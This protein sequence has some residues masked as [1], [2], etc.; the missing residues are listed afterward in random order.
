MGDRDVNAIVFLYLV[1]GEMQKR[2]KN[3]IDGCTTGS[4]SQRHACISYE[5][6]KH[7]ITGISKYQMG[8]AFY[9]DLNL[10]YISCGERTM[11]QAK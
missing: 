11:K 8:K 1:S 3:N 9:T 10:L 5:D 6:A 2:T 7:T 4:M